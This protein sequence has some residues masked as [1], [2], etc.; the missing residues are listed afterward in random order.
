MNYPHI[1]RKTTDPVSAPPEAG[2]HW[3][4][5]TTGTEFFSVGVATVDDWM[6]RFSSA[7]VSD[8]GALTGL[9]DDDHTQYHNDSRGDA[10]YY[11]KSQSDI[12]YEP[13]NTNIQSHISDVN[14][15]HSVTKTQLGLGN[16]PNLDTSTTSN[17]TDST[18]KRF[19]TEA[20]K[21]VIGIT[22]GTN[23]GDQD[24]SPYELLSNK[25]T[26]FSVIN[27]TKYPTTQAVR[28]E[29]N[30]SITVNP[31]Y[32][33]SGVNS[34]VSG[35]ESAPRLEDFTVGA[36][37]SIAQTVTTSE[38]LLEE[39]VTNLGFPNV[40]AL[41]VGIV[42]AHWET[43]KSSGSNNYYSYFKLF[44]RDLSGTETL[45]LTSD[46]SS[47]SAL[48]TVQQV[49]VVAFNGSIINL[50]NTDRIVIKV[51]ARMLS[52][53]ATI[54]L[55]WDDN[56]DARLQLPGSSL[57]YVPENVENKDNG[58]L[59]SSTTTYPTSFAVKTY[60][61]A[62]AG[63]LGNAFETV[64]KNLKAY[65]YTL[66]YTVDTLTSIVYTVP[67]VGTITKTLNYTVDKLTSIVLSGDTPSGI[68]LTKTLGYTVDKL[69][70]IT[71]S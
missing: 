30:S 41:P 16:V 71:Y 19:V 48:N 3:I 64:A 33:L 28:S 43:E 65:D 8:H 70:S 10:R 24:L 34:D 11:T 58:S 15:P 50:L 63:G 53:T 51:Y 4:N 23:T 56:T 1:I 35:Y 22:S 2:I 55:R 21:V 17:I 25:A 37:A 31:V 61:D 59:S 9:A 67:S 29:I 42:S 39:F 68:E 60:V 54:T 36:I 40:N 7:G 12:N 62:N 38:T 66:N 69:T 6:P 57:S 46:N 32:M 52:S 27:N 14:N 20:E 18:D 13:K 44:K 5:T 45:L 49:S 47:E 26:D